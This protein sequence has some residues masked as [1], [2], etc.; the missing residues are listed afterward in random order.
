L[1]DKAIVTVFC[2]ILMMVMCIQ[3]VGMMST[4]VSKINFDHACKNT[5]FQI[6]L[7]G[8]L[9]EENRQNLIL[10]LTGSGYTNITVQ[11]PSAVQYGEWIS[12]RVT[13]SS[14]IRSWN[15]FLS[16]EN[17]RDMEFVYD[18]RILSRKIHNDAY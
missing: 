12:F 10:R 17:R 9:T 15:G 7:D 4:V 1:L 6:D 2:L 3:L 8:G 5:L 18:Q 16:D 14:P 13:A 11:G